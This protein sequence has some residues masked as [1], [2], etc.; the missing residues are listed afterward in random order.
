MKLTVSL[1][2]LF[3]PFCWSA[4]GEPS[5]C[6]NECEIDKDQ[7]YC[8]E[9]DPSDKCPK[10]KRYYYDSN[11]KRC[12]KFG[13]EGCGGNENSFESRKECNEHCKKNCRPGK[14][15]K[16]KSDKNG[17]RETKKGERKAKQEAKKMER[18]EKN[19]GKVNKKSSDKKEER[20]RK[21]AERK[22][23]K[24]AKKRER[25]EKKASRKAEREEKKAARK[26]E[27]EAKK[28]D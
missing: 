20:E 10:V 9:N 25:E 6:P 7:G 1:C 28:N 16:I 19:A 24:E 3:L 23:R 13:F 8:C 2:L 5:Q 17:D 12:K 27:R 11:K 14:A 15:N 22:A 21:K 18:E 4:D 26:A